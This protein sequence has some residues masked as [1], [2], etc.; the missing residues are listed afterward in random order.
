M[1]DT[2]VAVTVRNPAT[3]DRYW[4]GQFLVDTGAFECM[5]PRTHLEAIGI[6]PQGSW[7]Y[8]LADGS[9][10]EFEVGVAQFEFMDV[11]FGVNVMFGNPGT[12]PLL[13]V[14]ALESANV[15][16]DPKDQQLKPRGPRRA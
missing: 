2:Y 4:E 15:I 3:P 6:K 1:G 5:V 10:T 14:I 8:W 9:E 13:G 12:Q 16:V 11:F 7:R